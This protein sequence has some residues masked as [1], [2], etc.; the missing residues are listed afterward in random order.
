MSVCV[1]ARMCRRVGWRATCRGMALQRS[2][3][4]S[5]A[6]RWAGTLPEFRGSLPRAPL[7]ATRHWDHSCSVHMLRMPCMRVMGTSV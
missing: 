5:S 3:R 2:G 4:R 7:P 6:P 1:R